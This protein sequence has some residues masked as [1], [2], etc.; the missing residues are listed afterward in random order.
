MSSHVLDASAVLA[1]LQAEA[2]AEVVDPLFSDAAISAANWSEVLQKAHQ[3]GRSA[4]EAADLLKALGLE[5][6]PLGEEDAAQAAAL[7]RHAPGLSLA[8][9]CCLALGLRYRA[10]VVTADA[11]WQDLSIGVVVLMIR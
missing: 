6:V 9:R 5:V 11:S 8:D 1:W 4:D 10:P 3:K 2:G 7:W